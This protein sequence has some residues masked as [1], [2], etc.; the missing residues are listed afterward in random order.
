[1]I[2]NLLEVPKWHGLAQLPRE[3]IGLFATTGDTL[4]LKHEYVA[5]QQSD[6]ISDTHSQIAGSYPDP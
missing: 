2:I 4:L 5:L 1:M 6:I 3:K